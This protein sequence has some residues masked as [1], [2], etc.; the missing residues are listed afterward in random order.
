MP[1]WLD[2]Y[3]DFT[4]NRSYSTLQ[5]RQTKSVA[6]PDEDA[7]NAKKGYSRPSNQVVAL[8]T[9]MTSIEPYYVQI[10]AWD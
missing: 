10:E 5:A 3:G 4:L 6:Y 9:K 1:T 7:T 8:E 2:T